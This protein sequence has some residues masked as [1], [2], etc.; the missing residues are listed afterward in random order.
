MY[1]P[2]KVMMGVHSLQQSLIGYIYNKHKELLPERASLALHLLYE[3]QY[4]YSFFKPYL[5]NE[6]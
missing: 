5:G 1:V 2:K 3:K 4:P 6:E